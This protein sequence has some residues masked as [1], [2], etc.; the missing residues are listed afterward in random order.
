MVVLLVSQL[1]LAD[2]LSFQGSPEQNSTQTASRTH[3]SVT[4]ATSTPE[5]SPPLLTVQAARRISLNVTIRPFDG[6]GSAR[7][8]RYQLEG[9]DETTVGSDL[10]R[11]PYTFVLAVNGQMWERTIESG[12][13]LTVRANG[14]GNVT[15]T[16][17]V[18][19]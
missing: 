12:Q 4:E 15:V 3:T 14:D 1:A 7:N 10:K 6:N 19:E 9:G 5:H 16:S 18:V 8:D 2:C 11:E 17:N 13:H